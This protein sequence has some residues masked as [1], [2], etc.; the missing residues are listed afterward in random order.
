MKPETEDLLLRIEMRLEE[1][2]SKMD[3]LISIMKFGQKQ[4]TQRLKQSLS[5]VELDVYS[6][7]DGTRT[8]S[9]IANTL[10][11][12]IQQISMYLSKLEEE[13]L[14]VPRKKGKRR[15]YESLL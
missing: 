9:E 2:S 4:T 14:I 1:I 8:V 13:G 11:K 6:L 5:D 10:G 12:S 15:Y 3:T 7:C